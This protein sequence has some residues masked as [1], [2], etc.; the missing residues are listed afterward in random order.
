MKITV[1]DINE[2]PFDTRLK[3]LTDYEKDVINMK[4]AT[5]KFCDNISFNPVHVKAIDVTKSAQIIENE[6]DKL[7]VKVVTNIA[8]YIDSQ[9]DMLLI[10][11][12]KKSI[13]ERRVDL[14]WHMKDHLH[15]SDSKVGE[16]TSIYGQMINL[17]DLGI[18]KP[19][20]TQALIFETDIL[21]DYDE[22]IFYTYKNK[23]IK[24][25][26]IALSYINLALAVNNK[27]NPNQYKNW[28]QYYSLAINPEIADENGYFFV[29]KEE[30][31]LENSCVWRGA[32]DITPTLETI[33]IPN[34]SEDLPQKAQI[35]IV[36]PS[37]KTL[38]YNYLIKNL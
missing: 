34:S 29:V 11:S 23:G 10:D 15:S 32:N 1:K 4:K 8:N 21:K 22:K 12:W 5:I 37:K 30:R 19:G 9:L 26:S 6:I 13:S 7:H 36:E 38:N 24:N 25:H 3:F 16:V 2:M 28:E 31:I 14:I 33:E 27:D 20:Q 18:N 35:A 17:T